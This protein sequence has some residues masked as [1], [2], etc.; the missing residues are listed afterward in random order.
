MSKEVMKIEVKDAPKAK[1]IAPPIIIDVI[2]LVLGISLLIWAGTVTNVIS[3][4]IG[5]L[6]LLYA[7]FNFVGYFRIKEKKARDIPALI[8]GIALLVAGI[9]LCTQTHFIKEVISFIVGIFIILESMLRIQDALMFRKS[10]PDSFKTPLI[11]ALIGLLCG[12]LC[13]L[14][15]ILIPD[16][17][18][19]VLGAMIVIFAFADISSI[20]TSNRKI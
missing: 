13:I 9:F 18:F 6:F 1:K 12:V 10:H 3:I 5:I 7:T 17:M 2:M 11:L 16:I 15:K 19:Q 8:T 20:L 14:G 4:T